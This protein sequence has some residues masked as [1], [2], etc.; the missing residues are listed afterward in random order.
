MDTQTT[1]IPSLEQ[2]PDELRRAIAL[3]RKAHQHQTEKKSDEAFKMFDEAAQIYKRL[4]DPLKA[5]VCYAQAATCWNMHA[6][7]RPLENAATRNDWA[8]HEAVRAKC[9]GYARRLFREAALLYE[10]EGNHEHYA[11]C[12]IA[13]QQSYTQYLWRLF[14][15][16]QKIDGLHETGSKVKWPERITALGRFI[17]Q[18]L[19]RAVWGY[20]ERPMRTFLASWVVIVFSA[21]CYSLSGLIKSD[22]IIRAIDFGEAFYFSVVTFATVGYGDY[23]PTGWTRIISTFEAFSGIFLMPLYLVGL[24]RR[25]LRL[26]L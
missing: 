10:K 1:S 7:W 11:S 9:F 18:F 8:A 19:N 23:L 4:G 20:G 6:G 16:G 26:N 21:V 14:F 25:Y 12:F 24:T 22:G 15:E 13:S 3:E 5:S 2:Q 17:M